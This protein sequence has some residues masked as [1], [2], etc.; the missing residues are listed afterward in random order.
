MGEK[1]ISGPSEMKGHGQSQ[2]DG[3]S[4]CSGITGRSDLSYV[5]P[6]LKAP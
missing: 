5:H 2:H 3:C 6:E 4:I 1:E